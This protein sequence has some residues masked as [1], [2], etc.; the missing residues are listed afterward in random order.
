MMK[1]DPRL[2][3]RWHHPR[4]KYSGSRRVIIEEK[5]RQVHFTEKLNIKP[6]YHQWILPVYPFNPHDLFGILA[7][8]WESDPRYN[9]EM[10]E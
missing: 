1:G 3:P 7:L 9:S 5:V 2:E 6:G 8:K 10:L 4:W